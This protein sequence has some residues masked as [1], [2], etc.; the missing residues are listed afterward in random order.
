MYLK[1]A[2]ALALVSSLSSVQAAE[3]TNGMEISANVSMASDYVWRGFSQTYKKPAIQGG[4][5]LVHDSGLYVGTWAS[6]VRFVPDGAVSDGAQ[7][8]WDT[9]LGYSTEF[10]NGMGLDMGYNHYFYPGA[11]SE[12]NYDFG[13]FYVKG[14]YSFLTLSYNY[15][16]EFFG[17][18]GKAHYVGLGAEYG[19]PY[20][21]T[22][23][24]AVGR[25]NLKGD[26]DYTD[27]SIGLGKS[28][29]GL[30]FSLAYVDTNIKDADDADDLAAA[31][32]VFSV[33]KT[34]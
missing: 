22:L 5:D 19:L 26:G 10:K 32:A 17:N 31:R 11:N 23:S 4:L 16:P 21:I 8:E 29:F 12:R 33:G 13:E 14:S 2:M 34:F 3:K 30:D 20:D 24:G 28:F 1:S 18:S 6:N 9:Y 15:S 25:Q 27:W 7:V